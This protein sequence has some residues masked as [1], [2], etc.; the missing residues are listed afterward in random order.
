MTLTVDSVIKIKGLTKEYYN[1]VVVNNI[2]LEIPNSWFAFLRRIR[3]YY[4]LI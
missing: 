1:K 4:Y 2:N 3:Y